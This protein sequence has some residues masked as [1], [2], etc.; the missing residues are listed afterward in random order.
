MNQKQ[1]YLQ[2]IFDSTFPYVLGKGDMPGGRY[3]QMELYLLALEEAS[4]GDKYVLRPK[5]VRAWI[6]PGEANYIPYRN[7]QSAAALPMGFAEWKGK[8]DPYLIGHLMNS[9]HSEADRRL[10]EKYKD[11]RKFENYVLLSQELHPIYHNLHQ[12]G[13]IIP[14]SSDDYISGKPFTVKLFS[15]WI[16]PKWTALSHQGQLNH[17]RHV[18]NQRRSIEAQQKHMLFLE[19]LASL[20]PELLK[21][22]N[23]LKK[24]YDMADSDMTYAAFLDVIRG[25]VRSRT[26]PYLLIQF[27]LTQTGI[28]LRESFYSGR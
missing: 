12:E 27:I 14:A 1:I 21:N 13:Y 17:S 4:N 18:S 6:T 7:K 26:G 15:K 28:K 20:P 2:E 16:N 10:G 9:A 5:T 11:G 24:L 23:S 25:Y 19:Y 8:K 3:S 22:V